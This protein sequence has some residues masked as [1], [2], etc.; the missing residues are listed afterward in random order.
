MVP[1]AG[2]L[3]ADNSI[4]FICFMAGVQFYSPTH[5]HIKFIKITLRILSAVDL[6]DHTADKLLGITNSYRQKF[7]GA[8]A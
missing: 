2:I 7:V 4:I 5:A 1:G 8:W 6:S 3:F